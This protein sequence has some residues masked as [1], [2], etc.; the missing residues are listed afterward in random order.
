MIMA[1][2]LLIRQQPESWFG[3]NLP[4]TNLASAEEEAEVVLSVDVVLPAEVPEGSPVP[5]DPKVVF[6]GGLF[7]LAEAD[8]PAPA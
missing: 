4:V 8:W 7:V 5:S 6:P 2:S 1:V 3:S